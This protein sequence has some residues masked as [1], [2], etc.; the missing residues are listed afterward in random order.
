M[1]SDPSHGCKNKVLPAEE[2]E[3]GSKR[4]SE[5]FDS[6]FVL[7]QEALGVKKIPHGMMLRHCFLFFF[8]R[9]Q[10]MLIPSSE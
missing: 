10:V 2:G 6:E 5:T 9:L 4:M 3:A 1:R 8:E 7:K